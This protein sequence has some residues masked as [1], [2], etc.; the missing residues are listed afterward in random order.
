MKKPA[1]GVQA[2]PKPARK[3]PASPGKIHPVV[4]YP[5]RQPGGYSDLMSLYELV[6]RLDVAESEPFLAKG[7]VDIG[8]Q[9][10]ALE[11]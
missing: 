6:A 1:T 9:P 8:L 10:P 5:F 2:K 7:M 3:L 11:R 4:I